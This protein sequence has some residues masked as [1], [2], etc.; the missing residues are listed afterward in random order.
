MNIP[1]TTIESTTL[2]L[3]RQID[4]RPEKVFQAWTEPA[5]LM[6]W[7]GPHGVTTKA[8]EVD[9]HVGGRYQ[10]T[11]LE[12][13]GNI[14]LVGGEYRVIDPP[15]LLAFTWVLDGQNCSGG[16]GQYAETL[17]TIEFED[18]NGSC[19]LTLTHEFLPGEESK[20]GHSIGWV[21]S[22]DRLE[23]WVGSP[24]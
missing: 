13:D 19:R 3:T 23:A 5:L 15:K 10:L 11:L 18:M 1:A 4:T 6:Q 16:Q 8:A 20:A 12:P 14:V 9:L 22:L 24:A 21:G 2:T 17:V 7:F